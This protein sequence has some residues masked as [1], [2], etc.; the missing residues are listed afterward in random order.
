MMIVFL[1][2]LIR[3]FDVDVSAFGWWVAG[4]VNAHGGVNLYIERGPWVAE[5]KP[6]WPMSPLQGAER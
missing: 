1:L 6:W 5:Q 2:L 4:G 3:P